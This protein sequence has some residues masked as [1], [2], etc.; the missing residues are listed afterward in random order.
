MKI[1]IYTIQH[2]EGDLTIFSISQ[3][4][5]KGKIRGFLALSLI[6]GCEDE[7]IEYINQETTCKPLEWNDFVNQIALNN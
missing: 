6:S 1:F 7:D 3:V 5:C 2:K 4:Y